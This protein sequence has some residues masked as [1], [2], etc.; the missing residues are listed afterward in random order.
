MRIGGLQKLSL[1][2]YP[3]K[4]A[5]TVFTQ[6]CN[7][8]CPFCHNPELVLSEQFGDTI[9]EDDVFTF[10]KSR[11]D[12]LQAV[13]VTGGEPTIQ[14]DLIPFLQKIKDLGFLVKLDTNGS[15]PDVIT[16]ALDRGLLNFI[17]MDIKASFLNYNKLA[18]CNVDLARIK[19]SISIIENSSIKYQFRTTFVP[20]L[21]QKNEIEQILA[22][23]L[24]K[25]AFKLQD[26]IKTDKILN[27]SLTTHIKVS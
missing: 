14:S 15:N 19:Q 11:V 2:D 22:L 13:V 9:L 21:H 23:V 12:K 20:N 10:L 8:R 1:I 6:G 4:I 7:F 27:P 17:A 16:E 25:K 5:A 3:N 26:F 18:G 24:D